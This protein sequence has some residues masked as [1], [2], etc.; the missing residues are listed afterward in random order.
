MILKRKIPILEDGMT[1]EVMQ[2]MLSQIKNR[3]GLTTF[4][5]QNVNGKFLCP[6]KP[7]DMSFSKLFRIM[8]SKANFLDDEVFLEEWNIVG[9]F[10]L[11]IV[12]EEY[13]NSNKP[14]CTQMRK[15][16]K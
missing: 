6:D 11:N 13:N 8:Q 14:I 5:A 2:L 3:Y 4:I 16:K 9:I 7:Y 1:K 10:L 12:R 15:K